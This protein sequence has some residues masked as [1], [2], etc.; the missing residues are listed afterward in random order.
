[1]E[2]TPKENED[3]EPPEPAPPPATG[4]REDHRTTA[5]GVTLPEAPD[6]RPAEDDS[7]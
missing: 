6:T 5:P 4:E 7:A 1:M 2:G 3:E